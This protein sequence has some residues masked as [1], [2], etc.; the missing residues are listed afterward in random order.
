MQQYVAS[1]LFNSA[2]SLNLKFLLLFCTWHSGAGDIVDDHIIVWG[3]L[4]TCTEDF[5]YI[6]RCSGDML[7]MTAFSLATALL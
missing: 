4:S 5:S 6:Q 2:C 7:G 3:P 1:K